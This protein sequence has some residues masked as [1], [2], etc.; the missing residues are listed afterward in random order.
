M[1]EFQ[2]T[3][4]YKNGSTILEIASL[5]G[6]TSVTPVVIT[7]RTCDGE[8]G[9]ENELL[10]EEVD[11]EADDDVHGGEHQSDVDRAFER[12]R[13]HGVLALHLGEEETFLL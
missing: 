5:K 11:E 2:L 12:G 4:S 8:H 10:P 9:D 7:P 13:V 3:S 1:I 6:D